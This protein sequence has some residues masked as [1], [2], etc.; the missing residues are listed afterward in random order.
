MPNGLSARPFS[1]RR[2]TSAKISGEANSPK[3]ETLT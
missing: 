1:A 2:A 3:F